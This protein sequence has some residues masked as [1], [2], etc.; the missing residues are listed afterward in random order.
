MGKVEVGWPSFAEV[1]GLCQAGRVLE[2]L[3]LLNA[4]YLDFSESRCLSSGA[5]RTLYEA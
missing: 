4:Q 1:A 2:R 5:V 3:G